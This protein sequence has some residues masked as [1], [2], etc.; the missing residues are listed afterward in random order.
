M[1]VSKLRELEKF[2][3]Q[4]PSDSFTHYAIALEYAASSDM[5]GAIEKLKALISMNPKYVPAY[6]QLASYLIKLDLYR[7]A[8]D[9]LEKG[10]LVAGLEGDRHAQ[11]EMQECLDDL[12]A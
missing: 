8:Q 7:D 5:D 10:I 4:D 6:Q 11:N 12:P 1:R 9:I 2:L 3:E